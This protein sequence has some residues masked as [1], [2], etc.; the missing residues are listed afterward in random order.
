MLNI[1]ELLTDPDFVQNVTINRRVNQ[2]VTTGDAAGEVT[3]DTFLLTVP[4]CV[5]PIKDADD[6][7][8]LPEGQR[9]NKM[10]KFYSL[11]PMYCDDG[12]LPAGSA[13]AR[14]DVVQWGTEKYKLLHVRNWSDYG[15]Y[16]AI[17]VNSE[18]LPT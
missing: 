1:A 2:L 15:Y 10:M 4:M 11:Q 16:E 8:V 7:L 5:Q 14:F 6:L 12:D 18:R 9:S 3:I 13:D 17:G